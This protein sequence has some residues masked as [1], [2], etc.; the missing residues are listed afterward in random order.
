MRVLAFILLL[1][2]CGKL[3]DANRYDEYTLQ[4]NV[5]PHD[6]YD[7]EFV[8][9]RITSESG[10]M[11]MSE[12]VAKTKEKAV[13]FALQDMSRKI[14]KALEEKKGTENQSP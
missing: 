6:G 14:L 4:I 5:L 9:A 11:P 3:D 8:K 13:A 7:E 10:K 2:G 1:A 12:G